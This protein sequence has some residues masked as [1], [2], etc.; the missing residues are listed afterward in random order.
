[1]LFDKVADLG[2]CEEVDTGCEHTVTEYEIVDDIVDVGFTKPAAK[3]TIKRMPWIVR[4][5]I[6]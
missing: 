2:M 5:N 4:S 6:S 1:M 3:S